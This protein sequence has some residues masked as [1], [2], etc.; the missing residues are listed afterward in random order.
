MPA[1]RRIEN[2]LV[3]RNAQGIVSV[4]AAAPDIVRV[5]FSPTRDFGRDHSY[6]IVNRELGAPGADVR[7]GER[8]SRIVTPALSASIQHRPFRVSIADAAGNELDADDPGQGIA[9]SG[10]SV[11]VWKRLRDDE[12]VYGFG[13]KTGRLNKRGRQLGG[14]NYTMWNSD[15]FAYESRHGSDLRVDP[16]LP[17]AARRPDARRVSRQHVP[18]QLRRR[19][20]VAGSAVV[21]RR[22]RRARLLPDLRAGPETRHPALHRDDGPHAA[23]AAMGARLSPVPLQLL[24]G[25]ARP[26]HRAQL[27]RAADPGRRDL[28]RHPLP[29]RLQAVHVG[30]R[31][32]PEPRGSRRRPAARRLPHRADRRRA[33]EEGGRLRAVRHRRRGRSPGEEP[34]RQRLRGAGLALAG[35]E[36]SRP[37]RLSRLQQAGGARV[38]GRALQ[39]RSRT[40]A[41]PGSGTT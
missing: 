34:G 30:P 26:V 18:Q 36:E 1:P 11:R 16:V 24:P 6:A 25:V 5:R 37:Q 2:G 29:G 9:I 39:D 3:F 33:P 7:V 40:S 17:R 35:R 21:W 14:Y 20:H 28:A 19:P 31:A 32:L 41:S 27:P 4:T 38:V 12:Q 22:R 8:V 23:A 13:E 10:Q 15:T